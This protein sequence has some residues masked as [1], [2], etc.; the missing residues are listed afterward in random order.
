MNLHRHRLISVIKFGILIFLF[1]CG[2][3]RKDEAEDLVRKVEA[4]QLRHAQ[5]PASQDDLGISEN[6]DEQAFYRREDE[7]HFI[8]WYGTTLGHSIV[9]D[10]ITR[11]WTVD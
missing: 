3:S 10:S 4:Y 9:Y 2:P 1:G 11:K 7:H 8:V 5:L 6:Q